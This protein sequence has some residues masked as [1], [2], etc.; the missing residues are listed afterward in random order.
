M[1]NISN[2][3][4]SIQDIMRKDAGTY[5]ETVTLSETDLAALEKPSTHIMINLGNPELA[6]QT[7]FIPN[8]GVRVGDRWK[9]R[10]QLKVNPLRLVDLGPVRPV[11]TEIC[12][13]VP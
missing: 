12:Y 2:L 6:F 4:K 5:G 3:I 1:P 11:K 9:K 10:R 7:S 8:D 13:M